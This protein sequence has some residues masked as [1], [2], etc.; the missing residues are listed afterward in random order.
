MKADI[1][2]EKTLPNNLEAERA[3][4]GAVLLQ[5]AL[6]DEATEIL[7]ADDFYHGGHRKIFGIITELS[8]A[9][10]PIDAV[11]L[12]EELQRQ[13]QLEDVGGMGYVT[14][15]LDGTPHLESV[16]QYAHIVKEKAL[17]RRLIQS[18]NSI[19]I[20]GY[21]N[22]ESA[23]DLLEAAEK[24][25]FDLGQEGRRS[26]FIGLS[27]LL[28]DTYKH[29]ESLYERKELVTG[30]PSGFAE[31]D[32]MTSGFQQSDL[33]IL[34][35]RPGLGK[36]SLALNIAQHASIRE[37]AVVGIF[38]LE[39][40]SHQLVMRL[41]CA[42]A[43]VDSHKVRSGYLSREDW[44]K[45]A[46]AMSRLAQARI[47]IDDTP[48]LSLM[49]MRSKAR[50]LKARAGL[51]LLIVD[52]MQ[53]MSA[54][55]AGGGRARHENRQQEISAISRSLKILAKEL[56]IPVL[57][58]SQLSRAPEQRRGDHKP[59]LSDLRESGSIEQDA[60]VVMFIYR[61]DLY[62]KDDDFDEEDGVAQIIIGKQRNGPTG[63][64]KLAFI[65]Q[66]TKFENL[67]RDME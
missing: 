13:R 8:A 33:L 23:F 52:Y 64:V 61:E 58:L 63:V 25:V 10:R 66:W 27:E 65:E 54:G 56:V 6:V 48:G 4:L 30:I 5:N 21:A 22:E 55:P 2:L 57:A 62:K 1:T 14:A 40:S 35:A 51:D 29:I 67:A 17:L 34:A 50:R 41:L 26:G 53:L 31:L 19:L 59:Q 37:N 60:D 43:R 38:S 9:S 36:T 44:T 47:Y 46:K 28:G 18:A 3:L 45:L 39:M 49:E 12:C 16:E 7:S 11:T 32:N 15:L 24:A 42:E 20:R